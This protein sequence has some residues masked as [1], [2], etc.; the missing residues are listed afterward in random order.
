MYKQTLEFFEFIEALFE[1]NAHERTR[2][3]W[4]Y[5][6]LKGSMWPDIPSFGTAGYKSFL[7]FGDVMFVDDACLY[8]IDSKPPFVINSE[9]VGS[10]YLELR[11]DFGR[12]IST[13][14]H[15]E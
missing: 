2:S 1:P 12:N 11:W 10:V 14:H 7:S 5:V 15:V 9:G 13:A 6:N 4:C 3:L 8:P